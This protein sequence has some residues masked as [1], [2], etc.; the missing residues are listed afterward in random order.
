MYFLGIIWNP[1]ETLFT[2]GPL[3]IKY[4]NLLWITAFGLGWY[5]MK[6]IFTNEN[7]TV[8]QLDSLFIHTV[9]ATMLGARLGHVFFYDWPYYQ[10]HLLE[11]LLPIRENAS[12]QLFG[13]INGYEFTGF[14]GLA[15]HGAIIGVLI[16]TYLYQKKFPDMKTLWLLDRMVIPFAIGAFCVRLGN[17]F[18]SEINGKITDESFVFATKFIRDSDDM[19]PSKALA[20]TQEKTVNAAYAALENNPK[21][22]EQLAQIPYR[23]PAQ[24]Y[25]GV[26]YIFVFILLYYLYWKTD[27][28]NRSGYLFGLFL[29]L[30]WTIR[31]FVE[32]VKKSQGGFEESLGL[33]S[34]GQWLSIPFIFIGLYFMFRPINSKS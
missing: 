24:L 21:F 34:T 26:A 30:L 28:K 19:H 9:L 25:E 23:H 15:S 32:F 4:Y 6:R 18:N 22:A 20:I 33:L 8:E 12:G 13:F 29:V 17:F 1:N 31:F 2:L 27:K 7:K 11:I 14:T 16:G 3:Q 10:N 5:I